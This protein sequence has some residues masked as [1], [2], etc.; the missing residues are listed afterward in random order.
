MSVVGV[1]VR[2]FRSVTLYHTP[3]FC[4]STTFSAGPERTSACRHPASEHDRGVSV[5][6]GGHVDTVATY[7]FPRRIG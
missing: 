3:W 2:V 4:P 1:D 7:V 5:E 6:P